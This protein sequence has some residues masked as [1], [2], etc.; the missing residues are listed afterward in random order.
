MQNV[1]ANMHKHMLL[2]ATAHGMLQAGLTFKFHSSKTDHE[3]HATTSG[4]SHVTNN[5]MKRKSVRQMPGMLCD[6]YRHNTP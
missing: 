6:G 4:R 2:H 5:L 1:T 3:T